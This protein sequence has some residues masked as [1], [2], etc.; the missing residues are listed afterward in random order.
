M[1]YSTALS[2][3]LL[4]LICLASLLWLRPRFAGQ[5]LLRPLLLGFGLTVTAALCGSVRY[6]LEPSWAELHRAFSQLGSALGLP[7]LG[8]AALCL[9]RGRAWGRPVWTV[10]VLSLVALFIGTR[11]L[12]L[13]EDYRLLLN[14]LSLLLILYAGA[15]QWPQRAP[16]VAALGVIGLFLIA[17]LAVGSEGWIGPLRRVDLFHGLLTLAYPLLAWLL[18]RL[19]Q[20]AACAEIPV[21]TL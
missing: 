6:G 17:G 1:Q 2:D 16:L 9:S 14:L 3:G 19:S 8:L 18:V 4:A 13:D 21:K 15:S 7:L 11:E 12:Q 20:N 5:P 10:L